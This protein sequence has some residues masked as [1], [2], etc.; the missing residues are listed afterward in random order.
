M[1]T[2][3]TWCLAVSASLALGGCGSNN[4]SENTGDAAEAE[5]QAQA[6][7]VNFGC[8]TCIYDMEGVTGCVLA[9]KINGEYYLVDGVDI[10]DL[11]D[12]HAADGLCLVERRGTITGA[13]EGDRFVAT[14]ASLLPLTP[15]DH[16][17]HDADAHSH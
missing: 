10:D 2:I 17:G 7:E 13:I 12:A 5:A 16:E 1:K 9:V 4:V 6:I 15:E 11:G 8:A 3:F 14:A